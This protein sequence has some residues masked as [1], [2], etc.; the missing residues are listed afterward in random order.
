MPKNHRVRKI[1][2]A[3]CTE[4]HLPNNVYCSEHNKESAK[5]HRDK[6][7]KETF[8]HY[9]NGENICNICGTNKFL[10]I[11]HLNGGGC[12]ERKNLK[13]PAGWH[14]YE[15]LRK[16]K[17]PEGYRVLCRGCNAMAHYMTD[18]ELKQHYINGAERIIN[19]SK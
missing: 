8:D 18:D 9:S 10:E 3:R 2:C 17:Y 5:E 4:L 16:M 15:Y 6:I 7:R 11:D 1:T 14:F 13:L 12:K 19:D